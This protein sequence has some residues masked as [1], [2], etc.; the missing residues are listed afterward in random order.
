MKDPNRAQLVKAAKYLLP[1]L[2]R[3]VFVGGCVTG[4]LVTDEGA[5]PLRP[6]KDVDAI[7]EI[8]SYA[9]YANLRDELKELGFNEDTSEKAPLCRW[10]IQDLLV[11]VM[12]TDEKVL[13]FT[14]VWYVPAI[15]TAINRRLSKDLTIKLITGPHFIATKLVAF[16]NRGHGDYHMSHDLEDLITVLDGR[17]SLVKEVE[18]S[19]DDLRAYLAERF[20]TLLGNQSFLDA[21][22]SHLTP[23]AASQARLPMVLS[24]IQRI[25]N[26][27]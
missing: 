3:I 9:Q 27:R 13:G 6:T 4:L 8:G 1:L 16:F 2:D 12:P 21:L 7:V 22:P 11:D 5:P 24:R 26:G 10:A 20:K 15:H 23:D 17:S 14:N 18:E 19:A 25:A